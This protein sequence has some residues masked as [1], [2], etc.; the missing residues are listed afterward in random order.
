MSRYELSL[1]PTYVA[2]WGLVQATR[3]LFQ[4]AIDQEAENPDNKMNWH[5]DPMDGVFSISS[6]HSELDKASLLMGNSSKSDNEET[7]GK[8]GEGYKLALLVLT[9]LGCGVKIHNYK[10]REIW[11]PKIIQ[12]RRYNSKI[13]VI[14][15]E[16]FIFKKPPSADLTFLI[17]NI[18]MDDFK[19]IQSSCLF[20]SRYEKLDSVFGEVLTEPELAG[21]VY[22]NGLFVCGNENAKM[23]F[24]YNLKPKYLPLDRDRTLIDSFNLMWLTSKLWSKHEDREFVADLV[25]DKVP[26]VKF[27]DSHSTSRLG[28]SIL[29]K[30]QSKYGL[31]SVP[32]GTE[33]E[34]EDIIKNYPSLTPIISSSSISSLVRG[35]SYM[36]DIKE[37]SKAPTI[38]LSYMLKTFYARHE[39]NFCNEMVKEF[40]LIT[41]KCA[42]MEKKWI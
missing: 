13:L 36:K 19:L 15:V 8:F 33:Y 40:E 10:A 24:G 22:V 39:D 9:R 27:I 11:T 34:R 16:K 6:K 7:I 42:E 25:I 17:E 28:D 14:D 4:N 31:T 2:D 3:E 20:M 35:S 32:V 1:S 18:S 29:M 30:F 26:D 12:S 5:Y 23:T 21:R 37:Q 38:S 41:E